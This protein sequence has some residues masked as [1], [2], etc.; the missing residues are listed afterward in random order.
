MASFNVYHARSISLP[1]RQ[2]PVAEQLDE[3]LSRLKSSQSVSTSS[4]LSI[5]HR[6]SDIKELY[7]CVDRLLQLPL[8]QQT[9]LSIDEVLD[10]SVRLLD[11]C[12]ASR[13]ALQLSRERLQDV[14]SCLRRRCSGEQSITN[15]AVSYLNTRRT[16]KKTVKK[17]MK[18]LKPQTEVKKDDAHAA[19]KDVQAVTA[20]T[21]TSMLSYIA[22]SNKSGWSTVAKLINKNANKEMKSDSGFDVVDAALNLFIC[23]KKNGANTS[24]IEDLRSQMSKLETEIQDLDEQLEGL[25]R[26]L[27]KTRAT[28]LN[29]ISY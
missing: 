4:S 15:E 29:I 17:C 27:V 3:Q 8:N 13:D 18:S 16:V 5:S 22:G 2:H 9:D 26:N 11:S 24:Q 1:S 6:L 25:F 19:L 10:G 14:Q 20:E 23:Q 21:L 12:S 7:S 28:L